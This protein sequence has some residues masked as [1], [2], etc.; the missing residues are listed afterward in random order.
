M[1]AQ[2]KKEEEEARSR[3]AGDEPSWSRRGAPAREPSGR[4]P[5]SRESAD[6]QRPRGD[7]PRGQ[8][9]AAAGDAS[10]RG[11]SESRLAEGGAWT[12]PQ[13]SKDDAPPQEAQKPL[14]GLDRLAALKAGG[15]SG[16]KDDARPSARSGWGGGSTSRD[17]PAT[18]SQRGENSRWK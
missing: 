15:G 12:R 9:A 3:P 18:E 10:W 7:A 8:T 13:S 1:V 4:E 14:A 6:W 5:P 2:R 17:R 16:R 11:G